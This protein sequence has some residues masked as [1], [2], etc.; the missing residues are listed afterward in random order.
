MCVGGCGR[1][2]VNTRALVT[3]GAILPSWSASSTHH[4]V[5]RKRGEPWTDGGGAGVQPLFQDMGHWS[6]R[7][8]EEETPARI[9]KGQ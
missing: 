1:I 9:V 3:L 4:T 7:E 6:A 5:Q 8:E 2:V